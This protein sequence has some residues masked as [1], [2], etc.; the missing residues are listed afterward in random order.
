[1]KRGDACD[2]PS[3]AGPR[4]RHTPGPTRVSAGAGGEAASRPVPPCGHLPLQDAEPPSSSPPP[5]TVHATLRRRAREVSSR[6]PEPPAS[7]ASVRSDPATGTGRSGWSLSRVAC[8]HRAGRGSCPRRNV[9]APPTVPCPEGDKAAPCLAPQP[10]GRHRALGEVQS[11]GRSPW[12]S[13]FHRRCGRE[14]KHVA[15]ARRVSCRC[16]R[17]DRAPW[18]WGRPP[19]SVTSPSRELVSAAPARAGVAGPPSH[20]EPVRLL[21][22]HRAFVIPVRGASL[23]KCRGSRF[24][25]VVSEVLRPDWL[26]CSVCPRFPIRVQEAR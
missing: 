15:R 8:G 23:L 2:G 3:R 1:M 12:R 16:P 7:P 22:A 18:T 20:A 25:H 14:T 10:R 24:C 19:G 13:C 5:P 9:P 17:P 4:Q 26:I 6:P 21:P 11:V